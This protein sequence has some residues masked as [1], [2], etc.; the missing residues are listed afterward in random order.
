MMILKEALDMAI[1]ELENAALSCPT[2]V[3]SYDSIKKRQAAEMLRQHKRMMYGGTSVFWG[4]THDA[5]YDK[6]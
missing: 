5:V 1:K 6:L 3:P 2:T 4:D